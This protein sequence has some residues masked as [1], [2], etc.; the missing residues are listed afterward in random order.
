MGEGEV[1]AGAVEGVE[2][3]AEVRAEY[4]SMALQHL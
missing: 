4:K 1:E 3:G 2:D